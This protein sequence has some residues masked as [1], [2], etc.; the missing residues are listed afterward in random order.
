M[1][2]L[3]VLLL[4]VTVR[5]RCRPRKKALVDMD[6]EEMEGNMSKSA[7]STRSVWGERRVRGVCRLWRIHVNT[8]NNEI[9]NKVY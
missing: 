6:F 4:A 7:P 2:A 9:N 8:Y 5:K 1:G 3:L